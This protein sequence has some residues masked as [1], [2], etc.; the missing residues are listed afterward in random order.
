MRLN[1]FLDED[2]IM[3]YREYKTGKKT[4]TKND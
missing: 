2:V 3:V 4:I 1:L